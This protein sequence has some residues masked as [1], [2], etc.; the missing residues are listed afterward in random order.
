MKNVWI[1]LLSATI[2]S[3][4]AADDIRS[5]LIAEYYE[6][7]TAVADFPKITGDKK[8]SIRRVDKI[9]FVEN[10]ESNFN[11]TNL[12]KNF[13]A[14]WAGSLKIEKPGKYKFFLES[15]DGSRMYLDGKLLV[16]NGGT[17]GMAKVEASIDLQPGQHDIRI[18]FFQGES[19]MGCKFSW[20]Q[21]GKNEEPVAENN[22]WHKA[23]AE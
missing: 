9:I 3:A 15:D 19:A 2:L 12:D 11:N 21:P 14:T 1:A 23:D 10:C 20:T 5:G 16:N 22:L 8:P 18:E 7:E 17:H 6:F 13:Y 4:H